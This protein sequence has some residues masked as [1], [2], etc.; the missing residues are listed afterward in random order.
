MP[1]RE[2]ETIQNI[3]YNG[4]PPTC[5][6]EGCLALRKASKREV[7]DPEE[8]DWVAILTECPYCHKNSQMYNKKENKYGCMNGNCRKYYEYL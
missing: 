1:N 5:N 8:K 7:I 4:H 6:C 3:V 2:D